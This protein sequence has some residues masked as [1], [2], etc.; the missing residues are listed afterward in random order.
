PHILLCGVIL[1][2]DDL[3]I[4]NAGKDAVPFVGEMMASRWAFEALAVEQFKEN[5]YM[6]RF[7]DLEKQMAQAR[8]RSEIL[9]TELMGQADLV[10]GFIRLNKP[11]NS[12]SQKL[13]IIQHEI[14]KLDHEKVLPPFKY[15][16]SLVSGKFND[17]I[18]EL[19]KMHLD[20][21]KAYYNQM[22]LK[23]KAEKDLLINRIEKEKGEQFLADQKMI[24]HNKSLEVLVTNSDAK[25]FF[26]ETPH[27]YMQKIAP[28][29]KEPDFNYG[30]AHFLASQKNLFGHH[31]D[32]LTFNIGVIWL[33]SLFLYISLYYNWLRKMMG[34]SFPF[35][36]VKSFL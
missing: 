16:E 28:I 10:D 3:K 26:R 4:K 29:Y 34:I 30:R 22:Y 24:Y 12:Y 17:Q 20:S 13:Q 1:M 33:M 11:L 36:P 35:K 15:T 23:V 31:V 27:G 6:A 9:T 14:I 7:F 21:L 19:A 32:T 2:F 25:Q 8:Y 5:R 18:A